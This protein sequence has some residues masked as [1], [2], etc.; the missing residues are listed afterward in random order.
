MFELISV[1][2]CRGELTQLESKNTD[3]I[4]DALKKV[5]KAVLIKDRVSA[6]IEF[7]QCCSSILKS[8]QNQN[9]NDA[10]LKRT[11][12]SYQRHAEFAIQ[13][14]SHTTLQTESSELIPAPPA[15]SINPQ[16]FFKELKEEFKPLENHRE[17]DLFIAT[18]SKTAAERYRVFISPN[19]LVKLKI[20][21]WGESKR[22][23][24]KPFSTGNKRHMILL[25]VCGDLYS[26]VDGQPFIH[27][28]FTNSFQHS[29]F[30]RG[31]NSLFGGDIKT[32]SEG[33]VTFITNSCG[34]YPSYRKRLIAF[35]EAL[36]SH[37]CLDN[38]SL[39]INV[40]NS[41]L[42]RKISS[43]DALKLDDENM[44]FFDPCTEKA[45]LNCRNVRH[46]TR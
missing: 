19:G 39:E 36:R 13:V 33:R 12:C 40:Y 2:D 27:T 17:N 23:Q 4:V 8:L 30:I 37:N 6:L 14:L 31:E 28:P 35:I 26:A 46:K 16:M 1:K 7:T 20:S 21:G 24:L 5:Y 10:K 41:M 15:G 34:R 3:S 9:N 42:G 11:L 44:K 25:S 45:K 43:L 18:L 32:N 22:L 38:K 29:T